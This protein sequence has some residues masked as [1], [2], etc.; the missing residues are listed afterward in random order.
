MDHPRRN[1]LGQKVLEP[2]EIATPEPAQATYMPAAVQTTTTLPP[3]EVIALNRMGYG[4]RPGDLARV[5]SMGLTAY[6]DEQLN[7]ASIDDSACAARVGNVKLKIKYAAAGDGSYPARHEAALLKTLNQTTTQLWQERIIPEKEWAERIRPAEEVRVATWVRAVQS[8]CQLREVLVEFWHNHFNVNAYADAPIAATFPVYDRLMRANCF[9]NFRVLLEAVAKST[10]MMYYLDNVSNKAGGGESGNEN[11]AREMLELHTLGS[12][13][14]L[15]FVAD[16]SSIG[17]VTYDGVAYVRGYTEDDIFEA[18]RCLTGWTLANGQWGLPSGVPSTGEFYYNNAWHDS[19]R[20]MVLNVD[21]RQ[22]VARNQPQLKDG[23]DLFDLLASHP[24][25]AR[26]VCAKLCRRLIADVPPASVINEA[27]AV[28]MANVKSP[29]QIKS[30]V[31]TILLSEA[32]RKSWGKKVKR[33][34]EVVVSYLRA[35]DAKLPDDVVDAA[36]PNKGGYWGSLF[37]NMSAS[38]H[39]IFSWP[40]PTGHPDQ[41]G[42]WVSTNGMLRRWNLPHILTQEWG[43]NM[44]VDLVAQTNL[45]SSCTQIVDFWINRLCGYAIN[46]AARQ[47]LISFMAQGGDP[48]AAPRPLGG[49]PDWNDPRAIHDRLISMVQL[50]AAF[51][52]FQLR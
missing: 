27:V 30:V 39:S 22:N 11:F 44:K 7:P 45:Q 42:Y 33:P 40:T 12:D 29:D 19:G 34:F 8:K 50:L 10:A 13:S 32:F 28:W 21:C 41:M 16:R 14:Y 46:A 3:I 1:F 26:N 35:T 17:T 51:R 37:W 6:V 47:E 48:A 5:R 43:G 31:R 2:S 18:A 52:E 20:K 4:P 15:G 9:G 23:Q 49:A 25:T 36:D 24:N 38:G